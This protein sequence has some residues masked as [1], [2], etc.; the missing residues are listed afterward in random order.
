MWRRRKDTVI[1]SFVK[2]GNDS[3]DSEIDIDGLPD[4]RMNESNSSLTQGR[5]AKLSAFSP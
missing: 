1:R 3:R 2:C 5:K 4:Y